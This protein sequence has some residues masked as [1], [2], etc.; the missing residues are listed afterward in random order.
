MEGHSSNNNLYQVLGIQKTATPEEVKKAYRKLALK[1]HPDKNP[2]SADK[3]KEISYAYE[4]L[5]DDQKRRVYDRYGELGLQMM[6][7]VMNPLFDPQVESMLFTILFFISFLFTLFILFLAFLTVRI[8]ELV[9]W[10]WR[11]VWIPMWIIDIIIFYHLI[12]F[13]V[14]SQKEQGK[15]EKME[16]EDEAGKKKR[17]EKQAKM[18]QRG[19]WI[20]NFTLLLLFQI[21]IV[22]KLDQV[23][24]SWTACQVF[25]P[26]FVFEGI[27]LIHITMNTVI[28]CVAIVSVQEQKQIP[29]YLFQQYWLFI[30]RL[31]AL[32][33]IALRIDDIIHCSWAIVFIPLYLVGL[34]YGLELIYRYYRYSRLPQPEIAHQG[35]ITVMF[36]MIIFVIVSVLVYAL[37]GLVARRLDGYVFVR[38]SHVFVPLFII[39]SFLLCCSGCCLPCLLKASVMPDLEEVDGDQAIIDSNRRITAS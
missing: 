13:I 15:D 26:Y 29:Y 4:V 24:S 22:L 12:R 30:L 25:I 32:I 27:Q 1:Y 16:E 39:F 9:L 38:M 36:G 21:F 11:V 34:K 2:N 3:F 7:T 19:V 28:G 5:G 20:I 31:C 14:S 8:D 10:P 35:K 23:L 6:G 17:F 18:V 37:V 33:L